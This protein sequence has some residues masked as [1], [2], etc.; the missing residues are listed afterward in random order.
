MANLLPR[1]PA[2]DLVPVTHGTV[3]LSEIVPEAITS[4]A[5]LDGAVT[6]LAA[7]GDAMAILPNPNRS[8]KLGETDFLWSGRNQALALGPAPASA[9]GIA[10]TDQ[11]DAFAVL[12]LSGTDAD[13]VL[14]RLTPLNLDEIEPSH[15]ARSLL[16]HMNT[17]FHRVDPR[18]WQ[19]LLFRSM[20]AHAVHDIDRAMRAV[21][22]RAA[23]TH[24]T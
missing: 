7:L 16:G 10:M 1:T 5:A 15:V 11:S 18:T 13:A 4:L 6:S 21:A 14:A 20:A 23:L 9:A 8:T 17:L 22:A 19:L 2:Q 3:T 12:H 24:G